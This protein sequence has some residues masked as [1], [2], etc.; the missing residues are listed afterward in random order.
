MAELIPE[1]VDIS[2]F[3]AKAGEHTEDIGSRLLRQ[4]FGDMLKRVESDLRG[5][6]GPYVSPQELVAAVSSVTSSYGLKHPIHIA[7]ENAAQDVL[8][9]N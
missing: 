7:F 3:V 6:N 1:G 2:K 4:E 8:G 5:L 9:E